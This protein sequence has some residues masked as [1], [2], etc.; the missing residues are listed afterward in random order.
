MP[1]FKRPAAK[2]LRLITKRLGTDAKGWH[3]VATWHQNAKPFAYGICL[4]DVELER[5]KAGKT[6]VK[7]RPCVQRGKSGAGRGPYLN[8]THRNM[9]QNFN[10]MGVSAIATLCWI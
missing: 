3:W 5:R 7:K 8:A 9:I 1:V 10:N 6:T 2:P 4:T